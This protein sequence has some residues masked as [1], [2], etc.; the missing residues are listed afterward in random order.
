MS[1]VHLDAKVRVITKLERVGSVENRPS[2]QPSNLAQTLH[3]Y[4]LDKEFYP[5]KYRQCWPFS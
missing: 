4:G 2:T 5:K 1:P 3:G